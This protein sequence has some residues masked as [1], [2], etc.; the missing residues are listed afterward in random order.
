MKMEDC[1][2]RDAAHLLNE[3]SIPDFDVP[4]ATCGRLWAKRSLEVNAIQ[5]T[6]LDELDI[7]NWFK[8]SSNAKLNYYYR[9]RFKAVG[10]LFGETLA[11]LS[12]CPA[13]PLRISWIPIG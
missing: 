6:D 2:V 13:C 5:Q 7:T 12:G 11:E 10:Y 1:D 3:W 4:C 8:L 9:G